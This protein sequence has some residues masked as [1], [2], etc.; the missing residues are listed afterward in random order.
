M[1]H[2]A[3]VGLA[4]LQVTSHL[5]MLQ[6]RAAVEAAMRMRELIVANANNALL[7]EMKAAFTFNRAVFEI[8]P[9]FQRQIL[10]GESAPPG[11]NLFRAHILLLRAGDH[12][13]RQGQVLALRERPQ[14]QQGPHRDGH[15]LHTGQ[16]G[17]GL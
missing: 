1:S 6:C 17:P 3:T 14:A 12:A 10:V 9:E 15:V 7:P 11:P 5:I 13:P 4:L 8:H 2:V 16:R